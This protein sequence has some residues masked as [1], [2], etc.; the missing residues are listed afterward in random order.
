MVVF[1]VNSRIWVCQ[2]NCVVF[3][4]SGSVKRTAHPVKGGL[5]RSWRIDWRLRAS[6]RREGRLEAP[7]ACVSRLHLRIS[8]LRRSFD[9]QRFVVSRNWSR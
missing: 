2:A 3:D 6:G 8:N 1:I 9:C 4:V 5:D 7:A